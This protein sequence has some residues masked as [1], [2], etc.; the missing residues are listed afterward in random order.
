M[1]YI[2]DGED[3]KKAE[4]K[5]RMILG[6]KIEIIDADNIG[7]AELE[8]I[9][10]GVTFFEAERRILIKDLFL[11]K[12]LVEKLPNLI[13]TPHKIVLLETK[14][15]KRGAVYKE[16]VKLAK[17]NSEI[18]FETFAAAE[19]TVDRNAVFRIFDL[20]MT[21]GRRA[22]KNLQSIESDN[23]PYATIG[24]WTKKAV[25][26][27]ASKKNAEKER[28]IL[29]RLAEID[30]LLKQTNFSKEPWVVLES[31]LIELSSL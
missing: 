15:D 17:T 14:L 30:M 4:Q 25:D 26:L 9:F 29:K 8:S 27:F 5:A 31:F 13:N 18:K 28:R 3:R 6:E 10:L 22:V 12:D 21:D 23:D 11:K 7:L 24:A 1:I 16:L 19:Q 20:A 2:F